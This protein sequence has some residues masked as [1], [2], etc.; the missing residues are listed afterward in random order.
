[1]KRNRYN[2]TGLRHFLTYTFNFALLCIPIHHHELRYT[3]GGWCLV[4]SV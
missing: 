4:F 1:M 2:V 3:V